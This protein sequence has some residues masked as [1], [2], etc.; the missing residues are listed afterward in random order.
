[1]MSWR[2][3]YTDRIALGIL[4]ISLF[5]SFCSYADQTGDSVKV[6]MHGILKR[7][8]CHISNDQ[9]IEISFGNVG[10]NKIDGERYKQPISYQLECEDP[11][12]TAA[13]IMTLKGT[14]T[15]F[16]TSAITT[17]V[18]GLGIELLQ[19][20]SPATL[21]Q[22]FTIDYNSP[23]T[24][25]AVPVSSGATLQEGTFSATATLLAEYE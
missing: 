5:L 17:S 22:G 18:S 11:D 20:G 8:P 14:Q 23:P 10:V 25:E 16:N 24:L 15:S 7:R 4:F 9:V 1:M 12:A 13:L 21:N 3:F 19:N 6:T 2:S